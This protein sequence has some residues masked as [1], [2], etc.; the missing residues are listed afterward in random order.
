M[1]KSWI[2]LNRYCSHKVSERDGDIVRTGMFRKGGDT[3]LLHSPMIFTMIYNEST[4]TF[5]T[6]ELG[7]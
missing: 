3:Y 4:M 6:P 7:F 1:I 2:W 5:A